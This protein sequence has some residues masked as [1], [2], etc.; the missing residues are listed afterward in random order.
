M[1]ARY[2]ISFQTKT[3]HEAKDQKILKQES[4][5][6]QHL[7]LDSNPFFTNSLLFCYQFISHYGAQISSKGNC[8]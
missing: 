5:T 8:N 7:Y 2:K 4:R 1:T 6:W 3:L